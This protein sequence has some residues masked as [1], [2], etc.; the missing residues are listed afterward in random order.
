MP[1]I[2]EPAEVANAALPDDNKYRRHIAHFGLYRGCRWAP[3]SV[4]M[5][6]RPYGVVLEVIR[7]FQIQLRTSVALDTGQP[8]TLRD[9][10]LRRLNELG[11]EYKV[12]L[13][14]ERSS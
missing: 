6:H 4:L 8:G 11:R 9:A 14:D 5:A 10:T 13:T 2:A 3:G 1:L 7:W 12:A